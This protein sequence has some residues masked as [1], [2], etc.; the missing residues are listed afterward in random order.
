M[1]A[2]APGRAPAP[3]AS[4]LPPLQNNPDQIQKT[5]QLLAAW[6]AKSA[7]DENLYAEFTREDRLVEETKPRKY[8]GKAL[9]MRP[10]LARIETNLLDGK[11]PDGT[12]HEGI[13]ADGKAVYHILS[14]T[15]SVYVYKLADD[16]K[17]RLL[18]EGPLPFMFNMRAEEAMRRF[19]I[20]LNREMDADDKYP[21]RYYV[22][23]RPREPIDREE[24]IEA[25]VILDKTTFHPI[26]L[27]LVGPNGKD[28]KT[29]RF[30]T[31]KRNDS[32]TPAAKPGSYDG[33]RY[34]DYFQKHGYKVIVDKSAQP[35]APQPNRAAAGQ[36]PT[37]ARRR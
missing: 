1:Q 27:H 13:I 25:L 4:V 10:N 32:T 35:T 6:E 34:A 29:F 20:Y 24:F 2:Q 21:A 31:V 9:L 15:K 19:E 17:D 18:E 12:F 3:A 37:A 33:P 30:D 7:Q 22:Q 11:S 28:T 23:I 8:K 36:A 5:R 16:Q 14:P 26:I